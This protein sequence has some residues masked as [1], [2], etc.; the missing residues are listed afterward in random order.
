MED[1][2]PEVLLPA[3]LS[4]PPTH[5]TAQALNHPAH[6][7]LVP[8]NIIHCLNA[9]SSCLFTIRSASWKANI[10]RYQINQCYRERKKI[11]YSMKWRTGTLHYIAAVLV[12]CH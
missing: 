3:S 8:A 11:R 4:Q 1:F 9:A 12:Q 6:P 5:S 2:V 7:A 10:L